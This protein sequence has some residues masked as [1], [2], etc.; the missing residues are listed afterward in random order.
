MMK[1]VRL[2]EDKL[3]PQEL[4]ELR[5][6]AESVADMA[7]TTEVPASKTKVKS[8]GKR[9]DKARDK[10]ESNVSDE[11]ASSKS[12]T[13]AANVE[14]MKKLKVDDLLAYGTSNAAQFTDVAVSAFYTDIGRAAG[15]TPDGNG[16]CVLNA[17]LVYAV[18][19][20]DTQR[21]HLLTVGKLLLPKMDKVTSD[22]AHTPQQRMST[23]MTHLGPN[24]MD[25]LATVTMMFGLAK[26][27]VK[28]PNAF[29]DKWMEHCAE[30]LP[31]MQAQGERER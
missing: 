27:G 19:L 28:P 10:D 2:T 18:L 23:L 8:K 6:A 20:T 7:S 14:K 13:S 21:E 9:K 26:L 29:L 3:N 5:M 4:A 15:T 16:S 24:K 31:S 11:S 1:A 22:D 25:E 30:L 17:L 12:K